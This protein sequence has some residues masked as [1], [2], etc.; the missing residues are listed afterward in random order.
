[1]AT[2]YWEL[3]RHGSNRSGNYAISCTLL[4]LLLLLSHWD[5]SL[6]VRH[7]NGFVYTILTNLF[8]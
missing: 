2:L 1:L 6:T 3:L 5:F 7:C 4:L 8:F